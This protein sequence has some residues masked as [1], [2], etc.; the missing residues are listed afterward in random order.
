V[1]R[2]AANRR[3]TRRLHQLTDAHL[4]WGD[5]IEVQVI[6]N[7]ETNGYVLASE[8]EGGSFTASLVN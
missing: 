1:A 5:T 3:E 4:D 6:N 8:A 7:L 2:F